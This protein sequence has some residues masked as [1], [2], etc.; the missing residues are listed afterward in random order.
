VI[1]ISGR[2]IQK[3]AQASPKYASDALARVDDL[4]AALPKVHREWCKT[5]LHQIPVLLHMTLHSSCSCSRCK[6]PTSR[7]TPDV[8][9]GP[10]RGS[11]R[12][13]EAKSSGDELIG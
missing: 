7:S 1:T 5:L 11:Q 2:T 10:G 13:Q 3:Q 4:L 6:E 8:I 12:F 9:A